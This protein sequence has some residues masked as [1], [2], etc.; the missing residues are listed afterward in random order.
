MQFLLQRTGLVSQYGKEERFI[1]ETF[2]E[3]FAAS[4]LARRYTCQDDDA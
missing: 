2:R 4:A 1:H 3:Y